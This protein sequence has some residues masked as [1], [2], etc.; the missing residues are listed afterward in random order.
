M[1]PRTDGWMKETW[2]S[3][4]PKELQ[5]GRQHDGGVAQA[6]GEVAGAPTTAAS[7]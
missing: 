3:A 5:R 6:G 4:S 7:N 1:V 2:T